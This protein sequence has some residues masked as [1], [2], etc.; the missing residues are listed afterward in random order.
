M[1]DPKPT[2]IPVL[3]AEEAIKIF[4]AKGLAKSFDWRDVWQAEHGRAF[5]VAK[6]MSTAL[7]EDTRE[8][9]DAGLAEGK[10]F[11]QI[12]GELKQLLR[13]RG[14]WGRQMMTDPMTGERKAVQLGSERRV[15]TIVN[16]NM[17]T[18]YA[19]GRYQR[20]QRVKKALPI[21]VYKSVMDGRERDE[22]RAWHNT[23]LPVD[24]PWWDT[25][26]PP[27]D[28]GCRCK[29]VSMTEG[30]ASRRRLVVGDAPKPNRMRTVI[31]K[32]TGEI[33]QVERGIGAGWDYHVGKS[34]FEGLAPVPMRGFGLNESNSEASAMSGAIGR[35]LN[36]FDLPAEGG[37][38]RD[39]TGWPLA[40]SKR[41]LS[42][43]SEARQNAAA[44]AAA[45]IVAPDMIRLIWVTGKDGRKMLVRR[46]LK[47]GMTVDVGSA[48]WRFSLRAPTG[49]AALKNGVE[50]YAVETE[51][52]AS[53][54]SRQPRD[55]NGRWKSNRSFIADAIERKGQYDG[56]ARLGNIG[57]SARNR[58]GELGLRPTAKGVVVRANEAFHIATRHGSDRRGQKPVGVD[59]ILKAGRIFNEGRINHGNPQFHHLG[60]RVHAS[61]EIDGSKYGATY[62]VGRHRVSLLT[63]WKR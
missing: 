20:I 46:Y 35:W 24:H 31:N 48:F 9:I 40:V 15:R 32:R 25:H 23:A 54:N 51:A 37:E 53:F 21:M 60:R 29:A 43:L 63:M 44:I 18:A 56:E 36:S 13:E 55:Q 6:M 2:A 62:T 5:T 26:Y 39:A 34:P 12:A 58:L 30:Q 1:P 61:A 38:Y 27:C 7:L 28:W 19:Q 10:S 4:R 47:D 45:A 42:G 33:M 52:E 41:W 59:D 17:R 8:I 3:P 22:H 16:T 50:I 57:D 14:W 49:I 11:G